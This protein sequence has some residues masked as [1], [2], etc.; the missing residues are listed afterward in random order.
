MSSF[1]EAA[2]VEKLRK[3]RNTP[4]SIQTLSHWVIY[5]RK[6]YKEIVSIWEKDISKATSTERKLSLVYL[7]NDVM[8]TSRKKGMEFIQG[9][10]RNLS[11]ILTTFYKESEKDYRE[12]ITRML[13]VWEERKV[14][15]SEYVSSIRSSFKSIQSDEIAAYVQP[16]EN[17]IIPKDNP[18]MKLIS[19]IERESIQDELLS[20]NISQYPPSLFVYDISKTQEQMIEMSSKL[21]EAQSLVEKLK[22]RLEKDL[23]RRS[24]LMSLLNEL[25][26]NQDANINISNSRLQECGKKLEQIQETKT[27]VQAALSKA[28]ITDFSQKPTPVSTTPP[29]SPP[30][31]PRAMKVPVSV[32]NP[33]APFVLPNKPIT[34]IQM[35]DEAPASST[36]PHYTH[37]YGNMDFPPQQQSFNPNMMPPSA[38][39]HGGS[40][41]NV[42]PNNSHH[43]VHP[44]P[45]THTHPHA[46]QISHN[47]QHVPPYVYQQQ[48]FYPSYPPNGPHGHQP[49]MTHH[50][51]SHSHPHSQYPPQGMQQY[52][53]QK[54][55]K[56]D[57]GEN[58]RKRSR[59]GDY[60]DQQ[61]NQSYNNQ[62]SF[63][64]HGHN[65][66]SN[67]SSFSSL[68]NPSDATSDETEA[69]LQSVVT[70]SPSHTPPL[71]S[72]SAGGPLTP[73]SSHLSSQV[74]S[75]SNS[76]L[77]STPPDIAFGNEND[78]ID[79][80]EDYDP[81]MPH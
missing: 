30:S 41:V 73:P 24:K 57:M 67:H 2:F 71:T 11:K 61:P 42:F 59:E 16:M 40:P 64:P 77:P 36:P 8:Q 56:G 3:L 39:H 75:I 47:S 58:N 32:A 50:S 31:D 46:H 5:H 25:L 37:P 28:G 13:D 33:Q 74:P 70:S 48:N 19:E 9:F 63:A 60:H 81:A 17:S 65:M 55:T 51:H 12:K 6:K 53:M 78:P 80:S 27:K 54:N 66:H 10:S 44:H 69:F 76:P 29:S 20:E 26:E 23:D 35:E 43:Q 79:D 62:H 7:A 22:T 14:F 72:W 15:S 49:P 1:S 18:L 4:H 68:S 45:H 34:T 38:Q 21:E 52:Q